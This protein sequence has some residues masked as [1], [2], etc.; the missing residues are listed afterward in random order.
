M[1]SVVIRNVLLALLISLCLTFGFAVAY[2]FSP[3]IFLILGSVW[4]TF[5]SSG[6]ES[7]GII[8]VA[9][10]VSASF[11]QILVI[12]GALIFVIILALLQSRGSPR[13]R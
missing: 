10:G 2:T 1:R 9:G 7:N 5:A 4:R 3:V 8:A 11:V 12:L 6:P 13:L